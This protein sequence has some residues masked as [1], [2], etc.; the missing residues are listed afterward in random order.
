[1]KILVNLFNLIVIVQMNNVLML[2]NQTMKNTL[3]DFM[4]IKLL[5]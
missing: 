2:K 1:M 5:F 3:E 4:S